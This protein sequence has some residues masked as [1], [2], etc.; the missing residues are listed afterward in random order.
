MNGITGRV[1]LIAPAPPPYGGMALQAI[2]LERLLR[3]DGLDVALF[4]S[5]FSFK[6]PL[7]LLGRIP[8]VRTSVRALSIWVKL[9]RQMRDVDTVH[10]LAAS[11]L[12]FFLVVCPAV[13]VGRLRRRKIVLNYRGGDAK[14]FFRTWGWAVRPIFTLATVVTAPSEFLAALIHD[15]FRIS[16]GIVPNILDTSAFRYRRR[17]SIQPKMLVARHLEKMYD[18]ETVLKAFRGVQQNRPDASLWIAGTGSEEQRL[19]K[20]VSQW[21][22]HNIRFLGQIP[23]EE[24]PAIYDQCDILVNASLA[25]NFPGALLEASAAGLVI[26]STSPGGIPF[27]YRNGETALLVEPGDWQG[28]ANAVE[29]IL[30]RPSM[31]LQ[32]AAA[33]TRLAES[34]D[35][36][37][38]RRALYAAYGFPIESAESQ[39]TRLAHSLR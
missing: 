19:R 25:D 33:A 21:G 17:D 28:L 6:G 36:T 35:W 15:R 4:P 1:L 10:I 27:I 3:R 14:P 20:L 2:K 31:G 23:H 16:V 26:V 30:E 11:W 39:L 7:R 29:S 38:V 12:Y 34:C 8:G 22:L 9:W 24:L 32:L 37:H 5:N 13:I 18:I